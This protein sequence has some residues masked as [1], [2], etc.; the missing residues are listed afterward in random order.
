MQ[1]PSTWAVIPAYNEEKMIGSVIERLLPAVSNI[2][3]VD[4]CSRDATREIAERAGAIALRH[5]LNRGQ[6]ASLQ[7]GMTY[8]LMHGADIIIHFDADG[9]HCVEDIPSLLGP[10][11]AGVCDVV[12]GSRFLRFDTQQSIPITRKLLLQG[13]ILFTTLFSGIRLTD[14]HNGLR[15]FSRSAALRIRI[16]ENQMAHASE[17][18]HEIVRLKLRT[19]EIP[20][21]IRYTAYSLE[22]TK[23]RGD[24]Q[25]RRTFDIVRRLIWSKLLS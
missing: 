5:R 25:L 18:L 16:T 9:Q 13:G 19:V 14:T 12:L 8:A 3:V 11:R 7:T 23:A 4:D 2:V 17:I 15:A 21:T 6:G 1:T 22:H 20:V 24:S 10:L